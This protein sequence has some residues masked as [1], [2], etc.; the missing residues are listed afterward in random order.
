[1][2]DRREEGRVCGIETRED[3][4]EARHRRARHHVQRFGVAAQTLCSE[5][6][7]RGVRSHT[8]VAVRVVTPLMAL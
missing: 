2:N 3:E 1:M 4:L 5:G 8:D 6:G 7:G